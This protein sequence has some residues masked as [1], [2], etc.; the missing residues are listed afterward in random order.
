MD[1]NRLLSLNWNR[2]LSYAGICNSDYIPKVQAQIIEEYTKDNIRIL[3][4]YQGVEIHRW[5][6]HAT[7]SAITIFWKTRDGQ[8]NSNEIKYWFIQDTL[9]IRHD[10]GFEY[11]DEF[12]VRID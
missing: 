7:N 1:W 12:F 3:Y 8:E 2:V 9:K 5:D 10:G 4:D 6:Y 11:Y